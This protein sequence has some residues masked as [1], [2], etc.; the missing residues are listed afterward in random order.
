VERFML[1]EASQDHEQLKGA[2]LDGG[3][4]NLCGEG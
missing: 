2:S 3:M 1:A 4:V